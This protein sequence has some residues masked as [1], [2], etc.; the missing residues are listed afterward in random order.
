M[1]RVIAS[2]ILVGATLVVAPLTASAAP[3]T[4]PSDVLTVAPEH[5]SMILA[6]LAAAGLP[7]PWLRRRRH[8]GTEGHL[9][10]HRN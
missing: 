3:I 1:N 5:G 4:V 10:A 9:A 2:L 8:D 7:L 6:C